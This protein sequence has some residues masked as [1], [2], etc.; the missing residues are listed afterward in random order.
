MNINFN[1]LEIHHAVMHTV[2]KKEDPH[3]TAQPEFE[4]EQLTLDDSVTDVIRERLI[5][6]MGK[7]SK[8]FQLDILHEHNG[9]FYSFA[10]SLRDADDEQFMSVSRGITS[11]LASSQTKTTIPG[12]YLLILNCSD[13]LRKVLIVIK[14]EPHEALMKAEGES[15]IT[16]LRQV[17]LSPSQKLYKIGI[18]SEREELTGTDW[19]DLDKNDKYEA[20]LFD[21]QFRVKSTPAEYFYKDFLGFTIEENAKIQSQRFYDITEQFIKDNF[22]D[23]DDKEGLLRI[24]KDEF[25]YNQSASVSP[26][27][28]ADTY[29]PVELAESYKYSTQFELPSSL[30][31]DPVLIR[32]KI[33]RRKVEFPG[34]LTLTGPDESFDD[35]VK[36][37]TGNS[38]YQEI[39]Q[40]NVAQ[41][42][43]VRIAGRPYKNE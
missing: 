10:E 27:E 16:L 26:A 24:L 14:A 6:A 20:F 29:F 22:D 12:G 5:N 41:F 36:L 7:A 40:A 9:S 11:L 39:E 35:R 15:Q 21:D 30:I 33:S 28:F 34:Q 32:N 38:I 37:I 31:K 17:F 2:K 8:A 43:F 1:N 13:D 25:N 4:D 18:L 23:I 42:T 19:D 3:E